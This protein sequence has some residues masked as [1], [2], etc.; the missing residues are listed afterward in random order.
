[1]KRWVL[2]EEC[3]EEPLM[4]AREMT[5][6]LITSDIS[7]LAPLLLQDNSCDINW[8]IS[9]STNI[10]MC[11]CAPSIF[12]YFIPTAFCSQTTNPS[13]PVI[14]VGSIYID[15]QKRYEYTVS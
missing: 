12:Y 4:I 15:R 10:R 14:N 8:D 2:V 11:V 5:G 1:V 7:T 13:Y 6:P 9:L 3:H